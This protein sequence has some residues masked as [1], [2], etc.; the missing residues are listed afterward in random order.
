MKIFKSSNITSSELITV[1]INLAELPI[2]MPIPM[3]VVAIFNNDNIDLLLCFS[4]L[5]IIENKASNTI[6]YQESLYDDEINNI[7]ID[8]TNEMYNDF[9]PMILE[10]KNIIGQKYCDL[11][12]SKYS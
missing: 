6:N 7:T 3:Y 5:K 2:Y 8:T 1:V 12:L 9:L 4:K 11:L 10:N